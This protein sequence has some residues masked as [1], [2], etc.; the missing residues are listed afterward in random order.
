MTIKKDFKKEIE[1]FHKFL[2]KRLEE[3]I[4]EYP[5]T[6]EEALR[7]LQG[8]MDVFEIN[9]VDVMMALGYT[10]PSWKV[11]KPKLH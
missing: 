2:T 10:P 8:S 5:E 6:K 1:N 3:E 9:D 7:R 11:W 4:E